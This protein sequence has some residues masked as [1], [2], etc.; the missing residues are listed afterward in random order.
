[1]RKKIIEGIED[2]LAG[3]IAYGSLRLPGHEKQMI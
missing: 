3:E 2:K 1:V